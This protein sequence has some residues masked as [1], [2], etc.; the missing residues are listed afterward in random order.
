MENILKD[1]FAS[2]LKAFRKEK[3]LSLEELAEQINLKYDT[4]FNKSM[5][6][7]WENGYSVG[8][9]SLKILSLFFNVTLQEMLGFN[10]DNN[11]GKIK[12]LI[13]VINEFQYKN[14]NILKNNI[15]DYAPA[16]PLLSIK[17]DDLK[18][19]FYL[20][21]SSDSKD[22]E[23]QKGDLILVKGENFEK[24]INKIALIDNGHKVEIRRLKSNSLFLRTSK[25]SQS[26]KIKIIGSA[27]A[28]CRVY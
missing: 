12:K 18:D 1:D 11:N 22:K 20:K 21:I 8:L 27:I 6:S 9:D 24:G 23:F 14:T 15:I 28:K 7:K 2:K 19:H 13:P 16:P 10:N 5:L 26:I 17:K 3:G 4:S 25:K